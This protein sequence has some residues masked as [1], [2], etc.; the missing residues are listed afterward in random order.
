MEDSLH[1]NLLAAHTLFQKTFLYRLNREFPELLPGQPKI[2]DYLMSHPH[3]FQRKIAEGCLIEPATLSPILEKMERSGLIRRDKTA[4]NRKNSIVSLSENGTR[5]GL[6]LRE[7]FLETETAVCVGIT[8]DEQE[9]LLRIL[10]SIQKNCRK[11]P[12]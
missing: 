9:R 4:D 3:S 2:I 8:P 6:R 5:L 12:A 11:E 10:R 1:Y 7:L